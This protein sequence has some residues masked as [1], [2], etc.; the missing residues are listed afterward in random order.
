[1]TGWLLIQMFSVTSLMSDKGIWLIVALAAGALVLFPSYYFL[2]RIFKGETFI[3]AHSANGSL[4]DP[5]APFTTA[6]KIEVRFWLLTL[7]DLR[8][9][10]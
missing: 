9:L 6:S 10:E 8:T 1:M 5:K 2:F 3:T 4:L 7:P